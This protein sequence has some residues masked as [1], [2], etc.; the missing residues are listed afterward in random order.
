MLGSSL[1]EI[2]VKGGSCTS[3]KFLLDFGFSVSTRAS[4]HVFILI[5]SININ[6]EFTTW[7][8]DLCLLCSSW[9][10]FVGYCPS[11]GR[12]SQVLAVLVCCISATTHHSSFH[13][14]SSHWVGCWF[15]LHRSYVLEVEGKRRMFYGTCR[16][17]LSAQ[18]VFV[19]H[20][21]FIFVDL[22][23]ITAFRST[24]SLNTV[25]PFAADTPSYRR[26]WG[27]LHSTVHTSI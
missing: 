16:G 15:G 21:H 14:W 22:S 11:W 12:D 8:P 3:A 1:D 4:V 17:S 25:E 13:W 2:I 10:C 26:R 23:P 7:H 24:I 6:G 20:F 27:T 9:V 18:F 5:K 19:D